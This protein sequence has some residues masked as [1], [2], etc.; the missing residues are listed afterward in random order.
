[1]KEKL[2]PSLSCWAKTLTIVS[3]ERTILQ[4]AKKDDFE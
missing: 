1:M 4:G 3:K 2:S